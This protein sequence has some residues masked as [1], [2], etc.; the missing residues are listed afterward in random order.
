MSGFNLKNLK[1]G[2]KLIAAFLVIGIVPFAVIGLV[3]LNRASD[4]L[5]TQSFNQL[6]G[7]RGIKKAQIETFFAERKGDMGVLMET[8]D[9]LRTEAISR[10]TA[11]R[12]SK[13]AS[14]VRYFDSIRDQVLTLSEDRMIVDA[15]L[16]F[17]AAFNSYAAETSVTPARLAA[18]RAALKTYYAGEFATEYGSQNDGG[19]FDAD[20]TVAKLADNAVIFQYNFIRANKNPLG[21]KHLLNS[22][23]DGSSYDR[24]HGKVHPIIRN[25]LEKFGYYDIF[26]VDAKHGNVQYSVFK[27]LDYGTSLKTGPWADSNLARAYNKAMALDGPNTVALMDYDLYTPSYDAPAGFIA[28]PIYDG[29]TK[30]GVLIFQMPL[31]RIA[32]IM[33]EKAGLGN[34]GETILVGPDYLMRS[35]SRLD[36]KNRSVVAS[37]RNPAKGKVVTAATKA[38]FERGETGVKYIVDYRK[39]P[40]IIAYTPLDIGG[41]TWS[42]NAKMDLAEMIVPVD[43]AGKDF[44]AKYIEQYGY[45]DLFLID[46]TGYVFY[47]ATHEADYQTNMV[48]GKY[49]S[50]GLGRLVQETLKNGKYGLADFAPYAPSNNEPAAF[51]AQA[52]IQNGQTELVVALQL[53][54]KAINTIMQQRDGM[55]ETGES[56]LIG[57]DNL[58]RSDSFLDPKHHSV[59]ASFADPSKGS[60]TSDAA[61]A[62]LAGKTGSEIVIDY[63]GNPVLSAYAPLELGGVTWALLA[64]IDEAEAFAVIGQLKWLMLILGL[65]GAAAIAAAGYFLAR[66]VSK[67]VVDMT[68]AMEVLAGGDKTVE[69][70]AQGRADEIGAMAG[71]VQVFKDNM[72]RND[73]LVAEQEEARAAREARAEKIEAITKDFDG[74]VAGILE[75]VASATEEMDATARSMSST[76]EKTMQQSSAVAA[77]SE[78][79]SANVQTVAAA[80]EELASSIDEITRQVSESARITSEAVTQTENTNQSMESLNEAAQKIGDVVNL[81][82]D[83]ASQTNLLALNATIEAARAGD[84]GKGF[85]VVASEVKNLATQTAKATEEIAAQIASMQQETNGAVTA[86][87][88]ITDTIGKI[89]EISSSVASAVEE[90]SA[91]TQEIGRNVDQAAKGTQEVTENIASVSQATGETGSAATEVLS[92]SQELARQAEALKATVETFLTDVRAA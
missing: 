51:T 67:P 37:F 7:V 56:Y 19:K 14:I 33:G 10:M 13:K 36:T 68:S 57:Q 87:Q 90:Q 65:V 27:E 89:N 48:N 26:L 52:V 79:A 3:A 1:I 59:I 17:N 75:T 69:I 50:S 38:V 44:Y 86:L 42:L 66:S 82:N 23:G 63:N 92:A 43:A 2:P 88:G 24:L 40:T 25:Y 32:A 22:L 15:S 6:E 46:P 53:S 30:T 45:Y 74:S 11:L 28:S 18:M 29:A 85:A 91:A 58:M 39:K 31:D 35:D 83:I 72:I 20:G 41:V 4:A 5:S 71:A 8:V 84:A 81:I 54:L 16:G 9:S 73:E 76:A 61:K 55:G 12:E 47:S 80:S 78:Q 34:T 21:S 60:V 49:S 64:E 77:A 70:P 62:A